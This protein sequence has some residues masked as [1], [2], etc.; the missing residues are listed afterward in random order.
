MAEHCP[1]FS[2]WVK[3][4]KKEW[5]AIEGRN[6]FGPY[7]KLSDI[8]AQG[9]MQFVVPSRELLECK[10]EDG[11]VQ[12][13]KTRVIIQGSPNNCKKGEHYYD[14]YAPAPNMTTT[15]MLLTLIVQLG[16]MLYSIDVWST[17]LWG[18]MK[19]DEIMP[20]RMPENQRKYDEETDSP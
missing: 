8:R 20:I 18:R 17:Y 13:W 2:E 9:V 12:K 15:R 5:D 1:D 3:A 19:P 14:T 6:T 16:L 11:E 7:Q 10:Q 4:S